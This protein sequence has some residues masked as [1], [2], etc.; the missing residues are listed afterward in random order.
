MKK[1]IL[2]LGVMALLLGSASCGNNKSYSAED[3]LMGDSL[4]LAMGRVMGAQVKQGMDREIQMNGHANLNVQKVL[5]GMEAVLYADTTDHESYIT[6]MQVGLTLMQQPVK[7]MEGQGFPADPEL[8]LKGFR[9]AVSE[10]SVSME[11]YWEQYSDL[12]R[13]SKDMAA[14][15]EIVKNGELGTAFVD[16][17]KKADS[18]VKTTETGLSYKIINVGEGALATPNDT[19]LVNYKGS[20]IDGTVFDDHS[21][22]DPQKFVLSGVVPGFSEGLSMLGEGGKAVFYIPGDLGYG[23]NGQPRAGIGPNAT[24]VFEVEVAKVLPAQ[25]AE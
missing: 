13:R 15:R 16:S 2:G 24:L 7:M 8:I 14:Q 12:D 9:E 1:T 5:R 10:D 3:K 25:V 6:G 18:E 17:V 20:L 4:S 21:E 11:K 19:V 22:G 23:N